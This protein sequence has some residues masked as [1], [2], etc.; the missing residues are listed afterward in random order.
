MCISLCAESAESLG[1]LQGIPYLDSLLAAF[2]QDD[3][4][5]LYPKLQFLKTGGG[6]GWEFIKNVEELG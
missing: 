3:I 2:P 4:T 5:H 1:F 6:R